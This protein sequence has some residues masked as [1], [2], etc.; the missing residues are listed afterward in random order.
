ME[1]TFPLK[2]FVISENLRMDTFV[3]RGLSINSDN[4]KV[5]FGDRSTPQ[6]R[7][8]LGKGDVKLPR[9]GSSAKQNHASRR[10]CT[11]PATCPRAVR[12]DRRCYCTGSPLV[13]LYLFNLRTYVTVPEFPWQGLNTPILRGVGAPAKREIPI[14]IDLNRRSSNSGAKI[15]SGTIISRGVRRG[16]ENN[17]KPRGGLGLHQWRT[18]PALGK[19]YSSTQFLDVLSQ[20]AANSTEG[21]VQ[22]GCQGSH[23]SR[24]GEGHERQ[25]QK[26]FHQALADFIP[27]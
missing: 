17:T 4:S 14:S 7:Y 23:S 22:A 25:N 11:V 10:S 5:L 12:V 20:D 9:K 27:V 1:S 26:V 2:T 21:A 24:S 16:R 19:P 3:Y 6:S 8:Q 18:Q 13:I 15:A